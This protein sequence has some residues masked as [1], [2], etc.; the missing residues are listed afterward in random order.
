MAEKQKR[1]RPEWTHLDSLG[2][3]RMVDVGE[4]PVTRRVA[5]ARAVVRMRPATLRRIREGNIEKG[6]AFAVARLAGI[7]AAKRTADLIPLCHPLPLE[8]V[9]VDLTPRGRDRVEIE[10]EVRVT[11]KTGAEMEALVAATAAALALYDMCKAVD[12]EM[13]IA[14]VALVEKSG[15]RSGHFRR[16]DRA[17]NR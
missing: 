16:S 7:Q 8:V 12:R 3:A 6:D 4:K 14:E 17:G 11:A 10:S 15:G 9:R 2:R 5:V 1:K 13:T